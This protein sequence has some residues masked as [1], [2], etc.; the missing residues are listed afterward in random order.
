[1]DSKKSNKGKEF[2]NNRKKR[3]TNSSQN[4]SYHKKRP[5]SS[6]KKE[7]SFKKLKPG[8][9]RKLKEVFAKIGVPE[10]KEFK[11][12]RFQQQALD[13]IPEEDCIVSAATGA[14]KTWIAEVAMEK[15]F[16][17][18]G[19]SWY[20]SPLKALTNT[21]YKSF[22][23]KFGAEN[24]GILTGDRKE[25]PDAPIVI[26][27][28]EILRNHLYDAMHEGRDIDTDY[29]IMDE[30]HYLGDED[31][32]VVWEEV[33]IYL[34]VRVPV[35]LL[36]ATIENTDEI[37]GW[38]ESIRKRPCTVIGASKR[39][40]P[41]YPMFFHPSGTLFPFYEPAND[42][43]R[44]PTKRLYKKVRKHL[45]TANPPRLS[46]PGGLPPM[47]LII[48]TMEKYNLLPGIF[49]LKSRM[50]CDKSV[51]MCDRNGLR[52]SP[53]KHAKIKEKLKELVKKYPHIK[54]HPQMKY[55][56]KCGV[57]AHHSGHLPPWKEAVEELMSE[58]LLNAVFATSTVAA[59]VNFPARTVVLSNSDR[60]NGV[61]FIPLS[62]TELHQM[63]G[64]AGRRG[65]DNIGF[66][67]TL[68]GKFMD[69]KFLGKLFYKEPG[70]VESKIK[71]N[72][73]MVLN[74][75]LSHT[76]EKIEMLIEKSLASFQTS[77]SSDLKIDFNKRLLFLESC[78]YVNENQ[79]LT[80]D[81]TWASKLRID[82]PLVVAEGFKKGLFPGD[83]VL[84]ASIISCFVTDREYKDELLFHRAIPKS[85][86]KEYI[87][88]KK[89]LMPFFSLLKNSGFNAPTLFLT[90]AVLIY[91]W[92]M[93]V[94]WDDVADL[95][96]IA[97]GDLV[98]LVLRTAD[99]LRH[100]KNLSDVFPDEAA[101]AYEAID[102]ILREPVVTDFE[103]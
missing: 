96:E 22:S 28:T 17:S 86:R 27:T 10:K 46:R 68:P 7:S 100:I 26:G 60:F 72:F 88:I 37:S 31:R 81:G 73:S 13:L 82:Y 2:K 65:M 76:P 87:K 69:L 30:A 98:R 67:I 51:E 19:K 92:A 53:E 91:H 66:V 49:F 36:S 5:Y 45:Q 90:P 64:R 44:T 39:P 75:L 41:L 94:P 52:L 54:S 99:N 25:F 85:L 20:A 93:G 29:V 33:L 34:P 40:V 35:L 16:K 47:G 95:T 63:T 43:D 80:H 4:K 11:A 3:F 77:S 79:G 18:G 58:G 50:D 61:E 102:L 97:E 48:K 1:M 23:E 6:Q 78:G 12:D 9:D 62:P 42:E 70:P 89:E 15:I 74:L 59:G 83:P 24:V 84:L 103:S 56:A 14:G 21:L 38:M 32:G 8:S 55:V 57:A 101:A 71:I